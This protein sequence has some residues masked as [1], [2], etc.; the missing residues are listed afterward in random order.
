METVGDDDEF[1]DDENSLPKTSQIEAIVLF[2]PND[3]NE[4]DEDT[5]MKMTET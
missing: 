2:P 3:G 5:A 4:T 1:L